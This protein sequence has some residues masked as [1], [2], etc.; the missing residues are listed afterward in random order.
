MESRESSSPLITRMVAAALNGKMADVY[1][2]DNLQ[3]MGLK[4]MGVLPKDIAEKLIPR[5]QR[6]SAHDK[7]TLERLKIE[8]LID[9]RIKD[10]DKLQ[11]RFPAVVLGVGMGG[12][13]THI[14]TALGAPFLPQAFVLTIKGGAPDGSVERYFMQGADLARKLTDQ[15]SGVVSIQHF[16][17]IHD[18]WLTRSCNHIRLKL[19]HLPDL[20]KAFIRDRVVPGGQVVYLSGGARWLQFQVGAKNRFQVGGWGAVS[21]EDFISGN[22]YLA[23]YARRTGLKEWQWRLNNFPC[24]YYPE[25]EWGSEIGLEEELEQFCQKE[26]YIFKRIHFDKPEDFSRLAF[27]IA[28]YRHKQAG[29]EPNGVIIEMFS[30]YNAIAVERK[31]L[32]PLWLIFNT[33]DSADFLRGE[34]KRFPMGKPVFFSP[35]ATFSITPDLVAW[36]DWMC[37][38][39]NFQVINIGARKSHYPT[40]AAALIDW[41]KPLRKWIS[42]Q[43]DMDLGRM[44]GEELE[45]CAAQVRLMV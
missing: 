6:A 17:P 9:Q 14:A 36:E 34:L 35:L 44:T 29:T 31:G 26:G 10:Y 45:Y 4:C 11:Q 19:I 43:A 41:E 33:L 12:A 13:T 15:N 18:G 3:K 28:R 7:A 20:Y 21:A 8:H 2:F 38:L 22:T 30:Q 5:F 25:S 1:E 16:D 42:K 37:I 39:K 27:E 23:E 40:D 32:L 24:D